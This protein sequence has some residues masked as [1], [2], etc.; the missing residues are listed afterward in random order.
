MKSICFVA[1]S[2]FA[3]NAFLLS[4][5]RLLS[6]H[7]QITLCVNTD[8]YPL[9]RNIDERVHVLHVPIERKISLVNDFVAL[10][11]L[12]AV[13][14]KSDFDVV[15][16]IT[17]K[18]GALAMFA[19]FLCRVP[20]RV[21]TFT[22]QVWATRSGAMRSLLKFI[23]RL[24]VSAATTVLS[25]SASQ[26]RFLEKE[27]GLTIGRVGV[28]GNGSIAGVDVE[29][30][31]PNEEGRGRIRQDLKIAHDSFVF[32]FVGRIARDKGVFDLVNAF[33]QISRS[34][35]ANTS[36]WMVGPDE[37]GLE[38]ELKSLAGDAGASVRWVGASVEPETFMAGA[39]LLVLPSYREGF[40]LVVVEAA[41]CG[42]PTLAYE[43]DGVVDAVENGITG[44]LVPLRDVEALA[45]QMEFMA[46]HAAHVKTLGLSARQR[47]FEKFT[48]T[49]VSKAWM[50]FYNQFA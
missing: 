11:R 2:P 1:T 48:A 37:E 46:G 15:H 4:H 31:R 35:C 10:L 16:S 19:S 47:V 20:N 5:L 29:R 44:V 43:I 40:G 9:S 27:L 45:R 23:D 30:F 41:G 12:I 33:R 42:L 38:S 14:R 26:S 13:F 34:D 28:L 24:I 39:D 25:D 3:V 6:Q 17:P 22:G 18:G 50:D 7:F 21:H 36:L 8:E 32:L 49:A